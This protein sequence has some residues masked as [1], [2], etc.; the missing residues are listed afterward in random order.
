VKGRGLGHFDPL[1][2]GSNRAAFRS[3]ANLG[4]PDTTHNL[5]VCIAAYILLQRNINETMR[6]L[7]NEKAAG[8]PAAFEFTA[9]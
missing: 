2:E 4:I 1:D 5:S 8:T 6:F 7:N 3:E 9:T